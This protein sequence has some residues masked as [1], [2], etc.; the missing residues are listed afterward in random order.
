[1]QL[2]REGYTIDQL[3]TYVGKGRDINALFLANPGQGHSHATGETKKLIDDFNAANFGAGGSCRITLNSSRFT[4]RYNT[5]FWISVE[6]MQHHYDRASV[7]AQRDGG[8]SNYT[9]K[10]SN[11]SWLGLSDMSAAKSISIDGDSLTVTPSPSI[12]LDDSSGHWQA[13]SRR[14]ADCES[15]TDCRGR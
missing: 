9:I 5:D 3:S 11:V 7:D 13:A 8:K 14:Q 2:V 4:T 6:G 12:L 10:T 1:M 15:I